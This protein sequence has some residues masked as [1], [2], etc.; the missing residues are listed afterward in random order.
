MDNV[1]LEKEFINELN[2]VKT[3]VEQLKS[4]WESFIYTGKLLSQDNISAE[5]FSSWQRCRNRHLDPYK[6]PNVRLSEEELSE[7][8]RKNRILIEVAAP[9]LQTIAENVEGSGFRVDLFDV[10]LYLLWH[11]GDRQ[12]MEDSERRSLI[13]LG[14]CRSE[15]SSGT[16]AINLAALLEKPVQLIGPEHYN[17]ALQ[18]WTCSAVPIKDENGKVI[19]V[20]N[21]A[22]Y[23]WLIHKHTLGMMTALA[24]SI[25]YC[26]LQKSISQE[27]AN[28][29]SFK[30]EII[31]SITDAVIVVNSDSRIIMANGVANQFFG[32]DGRDITGYTI[33][34]IWENGNPFTSVINTG[35][36]VNDREMPFSRQGKTV[37]LIGTIRPISLD[38]KKS[39]NVIGTFKGINDTRGMIRNY[40]G[41]KAHFTFDNLVGDNAEFRQAI[42]LAKETAKMH[43]NILIQ[44]ES[45]TGKDLFAQAIHNDSSY[46][47]GPFVVINCAAIPNGLL[48][49]EF[50]GYEG[51][52]FTGAKK[53]GQPGKFELAEGGTVFLDEINSLP[54]DMQAKILRTL[55]NKTVIRVG[56]NEEIPVRTRVIAASNTDLWQMVQRGEFREDLFYR[57]NVI[58]IHIP[59][60]RER[61]DDLAMLIDHIMMSR[62]MFPCL[63]INEDAMAM[64]RGYHWPGNIRELENVLER[65]TILVRTKEDKQLTAADILGYPGMQ[66]N[67]VVTQP[68]IKNT[69]T[70]NNSGNLKNMEKDTIKSVLEKNNGNI[71]QAAQLLGISRNTLYRKMKRYGLM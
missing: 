52:A 17:T 35:Q 11:Y 10:D 12:V 57:I 16:N 48:E 22:G 70:R 25:E 53:G 40:V 21:A 28:V 6:V 1:S 60:L 56:G 20:I 13:K 31:E 33:D 67:K 63:E 9:F 4:E 45:G 27:L 58:T 68:F 19:A 18:H 2:Y 39:R 42:R 49:S 41:W 36:P 62:D 54:L 7:R 8:V 29:N 50:F 15:L 5:V 14:T 61:I 38:E 55:Q 47:D 24:Q 30:K 64:M 51:G 32:F 71:S 59:P 23:Y 26:M 34:S 43:S 37:R 44:G 66:R 46:A 69:I 65:S 3:K